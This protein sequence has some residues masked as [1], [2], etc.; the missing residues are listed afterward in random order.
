MFHNDNVLLKGAVNVWLSDNAPL[1]F[2]KVKSEKIGMVNSA[3]IQKVNS[4]K[5]ASEAA[6]IS[7]SPE[8]STDIASSSALIT[9]SCDYLEIDKKMKAAVDDDPDKAIEQFKKYPILGCTTVLDMARVASGYDP[10]G[11]MDAAN[12]AKYQNYVN[13]ILGCPF[14]HLVMNEHQTFH[15]Q[16]SSWADAID[17]IS[18]LFSGVAAKDK[19]KISQSIKNLANA[20]SSKSNTRQGTSLFSVSAL[21]SDEHTVEAYIYSSNISMVESKSK[22]SDSKQTDIDIYKTNLSFDTEMWP[23][24]A[25]MVFEK[26]FKLIEDWLNDNTTVPGNE[27]TNLCIGG[28]KPIR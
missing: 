8:Q 26:H 10:N 28:Y 11:D 12:K 5:R 24:Y 17:Q 3:K 6:S 25:K 18:N 13:R 2:Q 14:F 7:V 22:G 27:K 20:V 19:D 16:E 21:N 15:R 1:M 23:Y 4:I 9:G